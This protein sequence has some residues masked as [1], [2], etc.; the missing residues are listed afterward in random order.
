MGST[1]HSR[2]NEPGCLS[3]LVAA[4]LL[5]CLTVW[6]VKSCG[7]RVFAP[8]TPEQAEKRKQDEAVKA[9]RQRQ[10]E[11]ARAEKWKQ[12]EAKQPQRQELI[13]KLIHQGVFA[14]VDL[15][16]RGATVWVKPAFYSLTFDAKKDF[17]SVV[18]AYI[19]TNARD[20]LVSVTLKD[21]LSGKE[22]GDYG[23]QWNGIGLKMK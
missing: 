3:R 15:R 21:N 6:G 16:E 5:L 22:V 7:D 1:R 2:K 20:D 4:V 23:Q 12:E 11:Q 14:K 19:A 17:C 13:Q 18:Y 10:E 9:E 8:D